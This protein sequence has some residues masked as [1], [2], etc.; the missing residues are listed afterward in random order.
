MTPDHYTKL[1][2]ERR[3]KITKYLLAAKSGYT[4]EDFIFHCINALSDNHRLLNCN[5]DSLMGAFM[6]CAEM[7]LMPNTP[8]NH[9]TI[10]PYYRNAKDESTGDWVKIQ[11]AR[12]ITG[13]QGWIDIML[14]NSNVE[15][16]TAEVVYKSDK[17][18]ETRGLRPNL[19]HIPDPERKEPERI[20]AYA[21][22]HIKNA[23]IPIFTVV[24]KV[25]MIKI[26][27]ISEQ[28]DPSNSLWANEED[29][30]FAWMWR[31]TAVKQLAKMMPISKQLDQT[32]NLDNLV[33]T[34]TG[35]VYL[36]KGGQLKFI[37]SDKAK[38]NQTISRK[39]AKSDDV[40]NA[41]VNRRKNKKK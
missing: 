27:K 15:S 6:H 41:L 7:G 37:T 5:S 14:R 9:V 38:A 28:S 4:S 19:E 36:T 31:K 20:A 8:H 40:V 17:F 24:Y 3:S 12:V 35:S 33:D 29:D 11:E 25:D 13:Y 32:I 10:K 30:P 34:G 26:K 21:I 39:K 1:L 2:N 18:T 23:Q 22:A 16:I